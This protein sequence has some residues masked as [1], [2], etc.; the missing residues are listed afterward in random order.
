LEPKTILEKR[1]GTL[2]Y[3]NAQSLFS[4]NSIPTAGKPNQA[5]F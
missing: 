3:E 4:R 2:S 5:F 1:A